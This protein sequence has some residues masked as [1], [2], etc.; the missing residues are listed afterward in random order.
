MSHLETSL[1]PIVQ[2]CLF[3]YFL[4]QA[5]DKP[6]NYPEV[7][8]SWYVCLYLL[9]IYKKKKRSLLVTLS[10]VLCLGGLPSLSLAKAAEE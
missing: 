10:K 4:F 1:E 2:Y 8:M 9:T 5:I 7:Y 3:Q 6:V